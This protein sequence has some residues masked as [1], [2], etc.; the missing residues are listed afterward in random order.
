MHNNNYSLLN[1]AV[2]PSQLQVTRASRY[3]NEELHTG[4]HDWNIHTSTNPSYGL[5]PPTSLTEPEVHSVPT[6]SIT[7]IS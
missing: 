5:N 7:E 2:Y 3:E 1:V 4:C 6:T